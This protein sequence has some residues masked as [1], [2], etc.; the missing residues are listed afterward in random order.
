MW[1]GQYIHLQ[2]FPRTLLAHSAAMPLSQLYGFALWT[3]T[4]LLSFQSARV[5]M[6]TQTPTPEDLWNILIKTA[7]ANVG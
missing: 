4:S 6:C 7:V 2:S 5:A 1:M 3:H